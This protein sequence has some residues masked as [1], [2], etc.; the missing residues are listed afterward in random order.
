MKIYKLGA[1]A[2]VPL[3]LLGC[4]APDEQEPTMD[5]DP[6]VAEERAHEVGDTETVSLGEVEDSGVTGDAR[7]TVITMNETEALIEV[8]DAQPNASY[9]AGIYQ[10]TCDNVGQQRHE[11]G[12]VQTNEEGAGA[13]TTSLSVRLADVMDGNHVVALYGAPDMGADQTGAQDPAVQDPDAM[14]TPQGMPIAC[15]EISEHGAMGW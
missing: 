4:P 3:F 2:I 9:Q 15:G 8:D 14:T 6:A 10:G 12:A 11:L 7:F 13:S 1:L 5:E